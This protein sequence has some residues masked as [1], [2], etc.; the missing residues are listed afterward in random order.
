M[1]R[2]RVS[3]PLLFVDGE[4]TVK[5]D[6]NVRVLLAVNAKDFGRRVIGCAKV[7]RLLGGGGDGRREVCTNKPAVSISDG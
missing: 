1:H 2:Q 7:E 6:P 3:G 4:R 5:L